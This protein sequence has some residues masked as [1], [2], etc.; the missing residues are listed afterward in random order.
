MILGTTEESVKEPTLE[1]RFFHNTCQFFEK[2]QRPGTGG[3]CNFSRNT[4]FGGC[5][6]LNFLQKPTTQDLFDSENFQKPRTGGSLILKAFK[7]PPQP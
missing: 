1:H 7:N 4:E 6:I 3:Y 5:L 2:F